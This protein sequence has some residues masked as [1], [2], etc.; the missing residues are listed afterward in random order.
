MT[1]LYPV[2]E[3]T[4][5]SPTYY[6]TF[7]KKSESEIMAR[8]LWDKRQLIMQTLMILGLILTGCSNLPLGSPAPT[9]TPLMEIDPTIVLPDTVQELIPL[10]LGESDSYRFAAAIKLGKFGPEA[11]PAVPA[12]V[13]NLFYE[14]FYDVRQ[15]AAWA[16]GE[17]G[18][19]SKEAIPALTVVLLTD[20]VHVRIEAAIALGKIGDMTA[21]YS[22]V[23][24]LDDE[25]DFVAGEAARSIGLLTGLSFPGMNSSGFILNENGVPEIVQAAKDW[26]E[27]EGQYND[28]L[29]H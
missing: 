14:G 24:A 2:L 23:K 27:R 7:Q 4:G 20:F 6:S 25:D 9:P 10:L 29:D 13:I 22:L 5:E 28:W 12:L 16:L 21:I 15:A 18:S 17:I 3:H 11:A 26:W 1:A 8:R 19:E